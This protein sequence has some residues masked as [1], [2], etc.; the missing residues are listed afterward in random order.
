MELHDWAH[1]TIAALVSG[2]WGPRGFD[3]WQFES[4]ASVSNGQRALAT[5]AGPLV[6]FLAIWTGWVKMGNRDSLTDQSFGCS[7]VLAAL[8][9]S[10][11]MA[12][13]TGGGDL[14][15]GLKLLFTKAD[16]TYPHLMA[17]VGLL[18]ILIICIPPLVR[19]FTLLPSWQGRFIFF[20]LFLFAPIW[21][22]RLLVHDLLN[23]LLTK[24]ETDAGLAY[25]WLIIWT[26]VVL[27]GWV[28]TRRRLGQLLVDR[29]LPL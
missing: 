3:S 1:G 15:I 21:V 16:T 13:F 23:T 20:P 28:F 19:I 5:L 27:G 29:E 25:A 26:A 12:A 18:I 11:V 17:T 6:N 14:T 10:M 2:V 24:F 4:N 9:M 8:P 22:H 7:L